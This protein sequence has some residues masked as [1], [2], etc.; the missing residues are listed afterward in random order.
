[1]AIATSTAILAASII[2]GAAAICTT[3]MQ[4]RA[5]SKSKLPDLPAL[6]APPDPTKTLEDAKK[7]TLRAANLRTKSILTSPVG[8]TTEPTTRKTLLG[9][10]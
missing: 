10:S 7:K 1:M 4:A 2:G 5:A 6:P 9:G 8:L 3:A